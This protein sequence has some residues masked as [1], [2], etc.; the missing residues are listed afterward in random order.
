MTTGLRRLPPWLGILALCLVVLLVPDEST[1]NTL[2]VGLIWALW[3]ASLNITWGYGGQFSMAQVALGGVSAYV[4]VILATRSGWPVFLAIVAGIVSAA[5]VS[6]VIGYMCL[7]LSGFRFAIMTLAFALAGVGLASSMEITGRTTGISAP[8]P[9]PTL[10][11]GPLTWDLNG[12]DGGFTL[13]LLVVFLLLTGGMWLVLRTRQGRALLAVR[14]DQLLAESVGVAARRYRV[15]AFVL[16]AVAAGVAGVCQAQYYQFIYPSLFSFST[17]VTVIVVLVLGG[18]GLL[19]GPLVGGLLYALL[20]N[21][22]HIGGQFE[23]M[24]FGAAI[25]LLTVFARHGLTYYLSAAVRLVLPRPPAEPVRAEPGPLAPRGGGLTDAALLEISGLTKAFGGVRAVD[26]VSFTVGSAAVVGVI[27]PNG[28]GKT[29][30]FNL[31][32][33]FVRPDAGEVRWEGRAITGLPAFERSRRGL[34]RTFQRPRTFPA[35]TVRENLVIAAEGR[36]AHPGADPVEQIVATFGLAELADRPA[37]ALS[38]GDA[39][40]LGVALAVATGARMVLLDE[41][42][43][44]LNTG[45]VELLRRDLLEL[46]KAGCSVLLIEHHMELVL[47]V[48]DEIVVLDAGRV[49]A[50]GTPAEVSAHP[51]VIDAYL[52]S[53]R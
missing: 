6:V 9:W 52:G 3:A 19:F 38:Y 34:V 2:T 20:T 22:L 49:I 44:G 43:A 12:T 15:L 48:C 37:S 27:G 4:F 28:A 13:L 29:S 7:R 21:T 50:Q 35:L 31:V 14:E 40:R 53:A 1:Q 16:G 33:G 8:G 18:R 51:D 11:I 10:R 30:L 25:I 41:P 17:L 26:D 24:I 36:P 42:A 23:Q 46:R 45:D 32:S 5:V 39:K 47:D